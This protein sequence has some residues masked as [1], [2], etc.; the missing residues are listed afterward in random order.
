MSWVGKTRQEIEAILHERLRTCRDQRDQLRAELQ[1]LDEVIRDAAGTS[2]G[3]AAARNARAIN[4]AIRA[5]TQR[6][7]T[8]LQDFTAFII[9]GKLPPEDTCREQGQWS[10]LVREEMGRLLSRYWEA[11]AAL[12]DA[13]KRL[14][15]ADSANNPDLNQLWDKREQVWLRCTGIRNEIIALAKENGHQLLD[16]DGTKSTT[17]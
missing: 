9:D 12:A 15:D 13:G 6:Y 11:T 17:A 3:T 1:S 2:D 7:S 10:P 8:V 14:E 5:A 4:E 16:G